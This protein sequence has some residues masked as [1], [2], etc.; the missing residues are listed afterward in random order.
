LSEILKHDLWWDYE[1]CLEMGL[2]DGL[3]P[4][5]SEDEIVEADDE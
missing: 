3:W 4:K 1:K 5:G 2:V